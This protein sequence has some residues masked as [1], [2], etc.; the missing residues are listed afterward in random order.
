[1]EEQSGFLQSSD[2]V[3]ECRWMDLFAGDLGRLDDLLPEDL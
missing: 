3:M 2:A 1:M